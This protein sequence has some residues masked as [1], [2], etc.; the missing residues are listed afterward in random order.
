MVVVPVVLEDAIVQ[1]SGTGGA[2]GTVAT[3]S[4]R[5]DDDEDGEDDEQAPRNRGPKAAN[6]VGI[7]AGNTG[8]KPPVIPAGSGAGGTATS[9]P[10]CF[11]FSSPL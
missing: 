8:S 3:G 4:E 10:V 11:P 9:A 7:A 2:A 5:K 1:S 6:A